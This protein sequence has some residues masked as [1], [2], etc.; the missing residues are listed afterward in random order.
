MMRS[1]QMIHGSVSLHQSLDANSPPMR[2]KKRSLTICG[3]QW[4]S[5]RMASVQ[6]CDYVSENVMKY[7]RSWSEPAYKHWVKSCSQTQHRGRGR[8]VSVLYGLVQFYVHVSTQP[9]WI[10][11]N[12][13]RT[14]LYFT[15]HERSPASLSI[16]LTF[17]FF[18]VCFYK[19]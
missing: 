6:R 18:Y 19:V 3:S 7:L 15:D 1:S 14:C 12:F 5:S 17:Y 10:N 4:L 9:V 16:A 11:S 8:V 13:I 2:A